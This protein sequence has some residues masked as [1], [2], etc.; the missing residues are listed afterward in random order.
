MEEIT[1]NKLI[2]QVYEALEINSDDTT[3]DKRLV[4]D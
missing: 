3:I 4:E 1:L 2:F